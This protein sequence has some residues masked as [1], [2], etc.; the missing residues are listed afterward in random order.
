MGYLPLIV[1]IHRS[2][3]DDGIGENQLRVHFDLIRKRTKISAK[4][5]RES[6]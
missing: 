1:A 4:F 5:P 3:N 6:S 2:F